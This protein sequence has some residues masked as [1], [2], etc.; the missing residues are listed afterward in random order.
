MKQ[1]N[2]QLRHCYGIKSLDAQFD[3]STSSVYAIYAPNGSMKSSLANTFG[4]LA[5]RRDSGDRIFRDRV[6]IRSITDEAG[7]EIPPEAVLVLPPYDEVFGD[8]EK[9]STLLVDAKLRKRYEEI[10][11]DIDRAKASL[12]TA[13]RKQSGIRDVEAAVSRTF[14]S[15]EDGFLTAL[16]RVK[17]EVRALEQPSFASVT[18]KVLFDPKVVH[19]LERDDVQAA[20][21]EYIET[22]NG[23]IEASTYFR[24]GIF[25][26]HNARS[27][28]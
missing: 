6:T 12:V 11:K 18:Y 10:H 5:N 14:T 2:L 28:R 13:L 26:F 17:E 4:D 1:L 15:D 21:S 16:N 24:R 22:Y 19:F 20:I 8:D 3:F 27:D 7:E 25:D 23:L 9:A